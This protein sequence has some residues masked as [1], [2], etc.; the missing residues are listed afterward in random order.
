MK[1]KMS[2]SDEKLGHVA[3]SAQHL[4]AGT[5]GRRPERLFQW[6]VPNHGRIEFEI[7]PSQ[8]RDHIDKPVGALSWIEMTNEDHPGP[9]V[10]ATDV[11]YEVD[12]VA[13]VGDDHQTLVGYVVELV[14]LVGHI[15]RHR[16]DDI[17]TSGV[18]AVKGSVRL[19]LQRLMWQCRS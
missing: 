17:G 16:G 9:T 2:L 8:H 19:A 14:G 1:T 7:F 18:V 3:P 4:D 13:S 12:R 11:S 10:L 6:P 15:T 5:C